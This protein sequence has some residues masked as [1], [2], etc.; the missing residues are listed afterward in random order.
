MRLPG[1]ELN[2]SLDGLEWRETRY[3]GV[4]WIDLASDPG[5]PSR[6]A[7]IR[8]APGRGYPRHRHLGPEDVL[9]LSG[10]Y[11]DED[12]QVFEAGA[13]VRYPAGSEH[14]PTALAGDGARDCVLLAVAHGG[15]ERVG[16]D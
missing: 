16:G 8:M 13:F 11:E 7:L 9:V 4:S 14:S 6:T 1:L 12:G 15:T 5:S 10:G 2:G 3:P